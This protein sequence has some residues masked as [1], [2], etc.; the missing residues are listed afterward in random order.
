MKEFEGVELNRHYS[1][2]GSHKLSSDYHKALRQLRKMSGEDVPMRGVLFL[3][4]PIEL[5][6]QVKQELHIGEEVVLYENNPTQ[7]TEY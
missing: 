5:E 2:K 3:G 1:D 7:T 6:R 4:T